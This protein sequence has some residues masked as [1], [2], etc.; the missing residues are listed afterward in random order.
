ML[1]PKVTLV[2]SKSL[3][4]RG[5][6]CPLNSGF[7]LLFF[8]LLFLFLKAWADTIRSLSFAFHFSC[9]VNLKFSSLICSSRSLKR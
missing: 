1:V 3:H 6:N 4:F 2:K 7:F 5:R 9:V 8:A